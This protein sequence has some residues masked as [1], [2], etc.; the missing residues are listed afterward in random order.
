MMGRSGALDYVY[1]QASG[2]LAKSFIGKRSKLLF[3]SNSLQDLWLQVFKTNV[4]L[5][6]ETLLAQEIEKEA[7]KKFLQEYTALISKFTNPPKIFLRL[8]R[9]Y[10]YSNIK[11]INY[12]LA[13][14]HTILPVLTDLGKHAKL[15]YKAWPSI[16]GITHGTPLSWLK[17]PVSGADV[18][19][20][21]TKLDQQCIHELW[22]SLND[23]SSNERFVSE[24]LLREEIVIQNIIWA[25]RL[26]TYYS[27]ANDTIIN[28][29]ACASHTP[30]RTDVLSGKAV[31]V[32][33]KPLDSYSEWEKWEYN[34]LLNPPEETGLWTLDPRWMQK[35][36]NAHLTEMAYNLFHNQPSISSIVCWFKIKQHELDLIRT[37]AEGLRLNVESKTLKDFAGVL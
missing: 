20:L 32:L 22:N 10:E 8:L 11:K 4:P 24:K 27:L 37:A 16:E 7:E 36:A 34:F 21:E 2:K 18:K 9:T 1:A 23:L 30:S 26:K 25:L 19:K 13:H 12:A 28:T 33:E 6:P 15:H 17:E 35:K 29:L 14:K 3:E 5:V 31:Q